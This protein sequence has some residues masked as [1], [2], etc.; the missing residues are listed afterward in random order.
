MTLEEIKSKWNTGL[1]RIKKAEKVAADDPVKFEK[2]ISNFNELT[3]EMSLLMVQY[4]EL[5]G[6]DIPKNNFESGF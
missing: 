6:E 2:F 4:K 5:T 3:R 1:E